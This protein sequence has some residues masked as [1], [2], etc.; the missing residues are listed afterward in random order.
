MISLIDL[1]ILKELPFPIK[2]GIVRGIKVFIAIVLAAVA[3]SFA[4]GSIIAQITIIPPEYKPAVIMGLTT[5]FTAIDKW[6]RERGLVADAKEAGLIPPDAKELP[7]PP[8]LV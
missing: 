1:P 6:L 8:P 5:A 3:A 4:D 2:S 7:P